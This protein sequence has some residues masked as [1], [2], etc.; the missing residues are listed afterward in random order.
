M[1]QELTTTPGARRREELK[2]RVKARKEAA[3]SLAPYQR[4][5]IVQ[6]DIDG[7]TVHEWQ[8]VGE[9]YRGTG[10]RSIKLSLYGLQP[11]AGGF[12]WKFMYEA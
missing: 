8:S 11:T 6:K 12:V 2:R 10:I 5:P 9:A 1:R 7:N 4:R 3:R